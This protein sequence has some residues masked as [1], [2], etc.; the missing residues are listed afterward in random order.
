MR[1]N[2]DRAIASVLMWEGGSAIRANEPGGA[3]NR[4]VSLHAF[5][6]E[7][8]D[9]SIQ[10]LLNMSEAEARRIYRKNYADK[11]AFDTLPA[12]LDAVALH[13][14]VMFGVN[15]IKKMADKAKGDY[16]YLI[17]LM[18]QNKMHRTEAVAKFGPG[19]SDRF[20]SIYEMAKDLAG[21]RSS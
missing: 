4:G 7:H 6:E 18:M 10:D 8:P 17:I 9:A 13:G 3:V 2:W 21:L 15:G 11:V 20:V 12:G 16:A 19:W 5:R 1:E 14:A